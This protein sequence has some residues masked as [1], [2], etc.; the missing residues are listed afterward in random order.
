MQRASCCSILDTGYWMLDARYWMN[1]WAVLIITHRESRIEYRVSSFILIHIPRSRQVVAVQ[2]RIHLCIDFNFRHL[3][4][5]EHPL[6][7]MG[8]GYHGIGI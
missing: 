4:R 2:D 6:A 8:H 5:I 7:E 1:Q 3:F